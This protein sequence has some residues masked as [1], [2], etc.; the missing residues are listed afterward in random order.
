MLGLGLRQ[1]YRVIGSD[2][3]GARIS[4][5][6]VLERVN[7]ARR[8]L[9]YLDYI[10]H[11][12]KTAEELAVEFAESEITAHEIVLWSKRLRNP[13]PHFRFNKQARRFRRSDLEAWLNARCAKIHYS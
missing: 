7:S 3:Y 10:P 13:L 9:P 1:S 11:D 4:S 2:D 5:D 6:H 12:L 8:H